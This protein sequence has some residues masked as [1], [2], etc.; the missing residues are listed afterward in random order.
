MSINRPIWKLR[1]WIDIKKLNWNILS[2]NSN[3]IHL[4]KENPEKL[5]WDNDNSKTI[6]W[7]LISFNPDAI[8]L[9]EQ[10]VDK[11]NWSYLSG[12]PNAI[13]L[14]RQNPDKICWGYLSENPSI[15]VVD[16][17]EYKKIKS[18][19]FMNHSSISS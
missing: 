6:N 9:L 17:D 2:L 13:H 12:N 8:E 1:D 4:F 10:N 19:Y 15:Y 14:L 16:D 5:L 11:I 7:N 18:E 3:A